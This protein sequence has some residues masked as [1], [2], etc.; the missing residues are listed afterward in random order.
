MPKICCNIGQLFISHVWL[1]TSSAEKS[2]LCLRELLGLF[3][4]SSQV[5]PKPG[6]SFGSGLGQAAWKMG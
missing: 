6:N 3:H 5:P 4:Q 2:W 1:D